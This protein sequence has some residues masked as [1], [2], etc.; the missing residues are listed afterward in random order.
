MALLPSLAAS[1]HTDCQGF[2][3]G[4]MDIVFSKL[5]VKR[6][7]ISEFAANTLRDMQYQTRPRLPAATSD[8][9]DF[10]SR[11]M[12]VPQWRAVEFGLGASMG[13]PR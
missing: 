3:E 12:H 5:P 13:A 7:I 10:L 8:R 1:A 4:G 2:A 6:I 9:S 11:T